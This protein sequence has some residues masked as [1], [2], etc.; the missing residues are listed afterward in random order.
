MAKPFSRLA[1]KRFRYGRRPLQLSTPPRCADTCR[2]ALLLSAPPMVD[3]RKEKSCWRPRG[4]RSSADPLASGGKVQFWRRRAPDGPLALGITR[5]GSSSTTGPVRR[6]SKLKPLTYDLAEHDDGKAATKKELKTRR[7]ETRNQKFKDSGLKAGDFLRRQKVSEVTRRRYTK[8]ARDFLALEGL[9]DDAPTEVLDHALN[10]RLLKMYLDGEQAASARYLVYAVK[11][12]LNRNAKDFKR[13][14]AAL[15]GFG[16]ATAETL[17]DP[18]SLEAVI[19]AAAAGC[20]K[21]TTEAIHTAAASIVQFDTLARPSEVLQLEASWLFV[22]RGRE[23]AMAEDAI[24]VT[25]FPSSQALVDKTK[26]QDDTVVAN[27]VVDLPWLASFLR[28][29]RR[30]DPAGRF[31]PLTLSQ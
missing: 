27:E 8:L 30:R 15:S 13:A 26:Q 4:A 29:L 25:F 5:S 3:G 14:L 28:L 12:E 10:R 24:A 9:A 17:R 19:L 6:D 20:R 22:A 7:A 11:W 21:G 18:N 2:C 23:K 16:S 1:Q 31:F